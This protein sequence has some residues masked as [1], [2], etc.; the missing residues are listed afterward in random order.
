MGGG[1]VNL[2]N[3]CR[4]WGIF[5]EGGGKERKEGREGEGRRGQKAGVEEGVKVGVREDMRK[6]AR[7]RNGRREAKKGRRRSRR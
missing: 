4:F 7:I 3:F 1:E 2:E 6:V 5:G